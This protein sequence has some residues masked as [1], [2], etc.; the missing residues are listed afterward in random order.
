MNH[1]EA[2]LGLPEFVERRLPEAD[3]ARMQGHVD[4]CVDCRSLAEGYRAIAQALRSESASGAEGHPGSDALVAFATGLAAIDPAE[5]LRVARHLATCASCAADVDATREMESTVDAPQAESS[6]ERKVARPGRRGWAVAAA[7]AMGMIL[8]YP[9]YRAIDGTRTSV[10]SV[11]ASFSGAVALP[12]LSSTLRG[13]AQG[14]TIVEA[15]PGQ[16]FVAFA[17]AL[18]AESGLAAETKVTLALFAASGERVWQQEMD[19]S[20]LAT[21]SGQ[22]GAVL[23]VVPSSA[24]TQG[25]YVL[26]LTRSAT[27]GDVPV[28]EAPLRVTR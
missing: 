6:T 16:P 4:G 12:V 11:P 19:A 8:G 23:L 2:V 28:L 14:E 18:P 5:H 21:L 7:A 27:P 9:V 17:L 22:A 25:R 24:V 20:R 13:G 1:E 26:R 15:P 3:L 10:A